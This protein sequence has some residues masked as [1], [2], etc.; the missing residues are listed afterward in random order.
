VS[1]ES[2]F[3]V[4]AVTLL[5]LILLI[6][7]VVWLKEISLHGHRHRWQVAFPTT[8]GLAAND[9]VQVNGIRKGQVTAMHLAGDRVVVELELADDVRITHDSRVSV[10]NVGLMGEK[11]IAV[12]LRT[13]GATYSARDTIP[14]VYEPGLGEVMGSLGSTVE[15][16]SDLASEL[17]DV[18]QTLNRDG[19]LHAAIDDFAETSAQLKHAVSD[20]RSRLDETLSNLSAASRSAKSL[21]V[22][23]EP[24]LKKALDDFAASAEKLDQLT[25]HLDTLRAQMQTITTRV[26]SGDGTLGKLVADP[27]LYDDL[28][29][30]VTSL[31]VLVEDI[32]KNPKKYIHFS[33]F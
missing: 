17:R 3:K 23:R 1:A 30:S 25:G 7:G 13:T 29:S 4:G 21:T 12:D 26:N 8:G 15:A 33:I 2:E 18:A 11:V 19:K 22:D 6:G 24:Q 27:K 31:K 10:R 14:G 28:R 9:E 20:N 32:K 16:V 5:A